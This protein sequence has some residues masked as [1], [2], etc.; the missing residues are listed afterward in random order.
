MSSNFHGSY[1]PLAILGPHYRHLTEHTKLYI[2]TDKVQHLRE[3]WGFICS[4]FDSFVTNH[5]QIIVGV[6]C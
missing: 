3:D 2:F 6:I 4:K 1:Y 5:F